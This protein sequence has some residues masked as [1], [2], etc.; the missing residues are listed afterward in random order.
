[1]HNSGKSKQPKHC[2]DCLYFHN[3]GRAQPTGAEKKYNAWCCHKH[4]PATKAIGWCI[5]VGAKVLRRT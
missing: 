3:A 1:M 5:L 2:K 4:A